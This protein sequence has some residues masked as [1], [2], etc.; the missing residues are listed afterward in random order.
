MFCAM[1]VCNLKF[2][3]SH[4]KSSSHFFQIS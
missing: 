3:H 1:L 2:C 4:G